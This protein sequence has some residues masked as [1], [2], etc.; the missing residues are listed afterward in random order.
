MQLGRKQCF[1]T[2]IDGTDSSPD[3]RWVSETTEIRLLPAART[4]LEYLA[5]GADPFE[6]LVHLL[7]AGETGASEMRPGISVSLMF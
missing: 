1:E 3:K 6:R 2:S 7:L 5:V 4:G